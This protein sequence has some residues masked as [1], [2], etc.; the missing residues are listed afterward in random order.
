MKASRLDGI[1]PHR[2]V[3]E[4]LCLWPGVSISRHSEILTG[5]WRSSEHNHGAFH[6]H[7][8]PQTRALEPD[9]VACIRISF[10]V[11]LI[12]TTGKVC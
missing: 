8:E 10:A 11:L 6:Q 5:H 12:Q 1:V 3:S 9:R 2:L 4:Q 7:I